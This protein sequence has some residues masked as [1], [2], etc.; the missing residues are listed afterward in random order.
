[1]MSDVE[2]GATNFTRLRPTVT[3]ANEGEAS[4][5]YA[6][7]TLVGIVLPAKLADAVFLPE[8]VRLNDVNAFFTASDVTCGDGSKALPD[9]LV[10]GGNTFL[11]L[12][13]Q[14]FSQYGMYK[15]LAQKIAAGTPAATGATGG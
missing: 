6:P 8:G 5:K 14:D 2:L 13:V 9:R 3:L 1:M 10:Y 7:A 15:V 12:H 4:R 11:A